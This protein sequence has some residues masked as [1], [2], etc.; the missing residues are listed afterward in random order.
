MNSTIQT[1]FNNSSSFTE[2]LFNEMDINFQNGHVV[3]K[4]YA[5]GIQVI[6]TFTYEEWINYVIPKLSGLPFSDETLELEKKLKLFDFSPQS[7]QGSASVKSGG[8][9][10][11]LSDAATIWMENVDSFDIDLLFFCADTN[12]IA[13]YGNCHVTWLTDHGY[14]FEINFHDFVCVDDIVE[15]VD[16]YDLELLF[17]MKNVVK[18]IYVTET[19]MTVKPPMH[20][21]TTQFCKTNFCSAVISYTFSKIITIFIT[22]VIQNSKISLFTIVTILKAFYYML[23]EQISIYYNI[24]KNICFYKRSS[25][26]YCLGCQDKCKI[27]LIECYPWNL[28]LN[29]TSIEKKNDEYNINFSEDL[30]DDVEMNNIIPYS[31]LE[32]LTTDNCME[33]FDGKTIMLYDDLIVQPKKQKLIDSNL[34]LAEVIDIINKSVNAI[35]RC[36]VEVI[37]ENKCYE[38]YNYLQDLGNVKDDSKNKNIKTPLTKASSPFNTSNRKWL[39]L[40]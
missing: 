27:E 11:P 17:E 5:A 37:F 4:E 14:D 30:Y 39:P 34:S 12:L 7:K 3:V 10:C 24:F 2:R 21:C 32:K 26:D 20:L 36:L 38:I 31:Y 29:Y 16:S 33:I 1:T 15:N 28:N 18:E 23:T 19:A 13:S 40:L 8:E 22:I 6:L 9:I 25:P 35:H